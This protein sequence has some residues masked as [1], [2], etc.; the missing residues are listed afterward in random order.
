VPVT[1]DCGAGGS[2]TASAS[3]KGVVRQEVFV[4]SEKHGT[5]GKAEEAPGTAKLNI[6]G[7]AEF[8]RVTCTSAGNCLGVGSYDGKKSSGPFAVT[9][10]HGTWGKAR[11]L[12]TPA[13]SRSVRC[14]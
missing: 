8:N 4:V 1:R 6:G 10:K 3:K 7:A 14:R 9:E 12:T 11:T 13:V 2:Y 5:W